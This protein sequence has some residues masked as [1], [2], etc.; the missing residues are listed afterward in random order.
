VILLPRLKV[1]LLPNRLNLPPLSL[2]AAD[3]IANENPFENRNER[4]RKDK[5]DGGNVSIFV[6]FAVRPS[7]NLS[8]SVLA[9]VLIA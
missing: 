2:S 4:H 1:N 8:S 5:K 6:T 7:F 9:Q 3:Q